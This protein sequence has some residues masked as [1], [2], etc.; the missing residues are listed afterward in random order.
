MLM[1]YCFAVIPFALLTQSHFRHDVPSCLT[2][3]TVGSILGHELLHGFDLHGARYDAQG[4]LRDW[5]SPEARLG[6]EARVDCVA[7][8]Y[9]RVFHRQVKFMGNKVDVQV[10]K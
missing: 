10:S 6:L 2:Y 4:R 9:S 8:Q 7:R 5:L 3:A 1:N